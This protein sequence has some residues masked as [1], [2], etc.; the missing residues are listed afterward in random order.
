M[1]K[2]G[3]NLFAAWQNSDDLLIAWQNRCLPLLLWQHASA[4]YKQGDVERFED[5]L[6]M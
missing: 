5:S 1:A 6:Q 2:Y 4:F 3:P